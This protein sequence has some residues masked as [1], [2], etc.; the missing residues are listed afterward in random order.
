MKAHPGAPALEVDVFHP[1]FGYSTD[2][3][4]GIG[5]GPDKR[6]VAQAHRCAAIDRGKDHAGLGYGKDRS[7]S[8]LYHVLGTLYR[9]RRVLLHHLGNHQVI[10][11]HPDRGKMKFYRGAETVFVSSSM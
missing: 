9:A 10:E 2:A 11:E 6:P 5:H 8:L 3:C 7:L 4:E 1:H